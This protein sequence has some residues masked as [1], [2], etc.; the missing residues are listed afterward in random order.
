MPMYHEVVYNLPNGTSTDSVWDSGPG[1]S[2]WKLF[3]GTKLPYDHVGRWFLGNVGYKL[4]TVYGADVQSITVTGSVPI[5]ENSPQL[6]RILRVSDFFGYFRAVKDGLVFSQ[7][8]SII[9]KPVNHM[10]IQ[11]EL[12]DNPGAPYVP[13]RGISN[14]QSRDWYGSV[15]VE[16]PGIYTP[17]LTSSSGPAWESLAHLLDRIDLSQ[18][19]EALWSW[20]YG[21]ETSGY[22]RGYRN[23]KATQASSQVVIE[24]DAF[25]QINHSFPANVIRW[26]YHIRHVLSSEG[27]YPSSDCDLTDISSARIQTFGTLTHYSE[28][29]SISESD[30]WSQWSLNDFSDEI[31]LLTFDFEYPDSWIGLYSLPSWGDSP[32]STIGYS[33][34]E[35]FVNNN[36][37][38]FYAFYTKSL[39]H[40]DDMA[41]LCSVSS[42]NAI[43]NYFSSLSQN[44]IESLLE[45][46]DLGGLV[47]LADLIQV[48]RGRLTSRKS[49]VM[50]ALDLLSSSKLIYSFALS[51][52]VSS[53][54]EA[55]V[56][57]K[58]IRSSL[59]SLT[60]W[61]RM[62]SVV[63]FP[64]QDFLGPDFD[65]SYVV[66]RS[67]LYG[68]VAPDSFLTWFLP[69]KML[70]LAPS[71]S[72]LW[73]LLPSSWLLDWFFQIGRK[74]DVVDNSL[75]ALSLEFRYG[76][77]SIRIEH[78]L[79][80]LGNVKYRY[81]E[82]FVNN[83]AVNFVPTRLPL[84]SAY[85]PDW[86]TAGSYVY[87]LIRR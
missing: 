42:W 77:H 83:G 12:D 13:I 22:C 61:S 8:G 53:A 17:I 48:T 38:S 50:A 16:S 26:C 20:V 18:Y 72:N 34:Q 84:F 86:G 28:H 82:R 65:P 33:L 70:G 59:T 25:G 6:R 11:G 71:L 31:D 5:N 75:L 14:P 58:R 79:E 30:G 24:Y 54:E 76:V 78:S 51:P 7:A 1:S 47:S 69:M 80:D 37:R 63:D 85:I 10:N 57:A 4:A 67:K 27:L 39:N 19:D 64:L 32:L 55:A 52:T 62:D 66:T 68:R 2:G 41:A 73:D 29:I 35:G 44:H 49:W 46:S 9:D 43:D 87:K 15:I 74:L 56:K 40:I 21:G 36:S 23:L 45:L 60:R 81:F 3:G